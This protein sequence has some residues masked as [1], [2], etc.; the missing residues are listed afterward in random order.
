[1]HFLGLILDHFNV[2][3]DKYGMQSL[4]MGD[5]RARAAD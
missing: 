2:L 1:M 5:F 4:A 3:K